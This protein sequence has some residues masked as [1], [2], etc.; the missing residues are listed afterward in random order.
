MA[1]AIYLHSKHSVYGT[2][3]SRTHMHDW[4]HSK[5]PYDK[6]LSH[7]T[8]TPSQTVEVSSVWKTNCCFTSWPL[9]C[10]TSGGPRRGN[11]RR[12]LESCGVLSLP[13]PRCLATQVHGAV[14]LLMATCHR[15]GRRQQGQTTRL[16]S[17]H[18]RL[19]LSAANTWNY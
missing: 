11:E 6:L 13:I 10:S 1:C 14:S 7:P 3:R 9:R 18:K 8:T 17:S 19:H 4:R 5:P 16:A 2:S 15:R 12:A